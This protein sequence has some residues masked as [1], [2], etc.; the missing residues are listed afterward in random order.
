MTTI[1]KNAHPILGVIVSQFPELHETF[2]VRELRALREAGVALRIYSLKR[3]RDEIVHLESQSLLSQTTYVAW[4]APV[5]WWRAGCEGLRHPWR[6]VSTLRWVIQFHRWPPATAAKAVIV[7]V[8]AMAMSRLMRRDGVT[9]AHAH[10]ATMPTTAAAV[11]SRWLSVPMSFT[12]HAWDIF[13]PN[14]SLKE[15]V[16]LAAR[17]IPC[18]EYNRRYLSHF[19]PGDKR[20]IV[21][22]YHGVDLETFARSTDPAGDGANLPTPLFLSVG[23]LVDTKGYEVL[24]EAYQLLHE[25]GVALRAMIVGHGPLARHLRRRVKQLELSDVV[26]ITPAMPQPALRELYAR[27]YAFVLPCVVAKNGDRDGIPNVLLEAM[28]M[29]LPVVSTAVSGIPEAVHD[30]RDGLVVPAHDPIRLA[31]ALYLLIRKPTWARVLG[32]HGRMWAETQFDA[33]EHMARLVTHMNEAIEAYSGLH[34]AHVSTGVSES[35][36]RA[37]QA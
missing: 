5:V 26:E 33:R 17:V 22:N 28:A 20:K 7:W 37:E 32:D 14:A 29:G 35:S 9:H 25:R 24:L 23:R 11:V 19:C 36:V 16:R 30:K 6:R 13:V 21:L 15:K 18:T 31:D 27:A 3:C 12:A 8:Q 34:Q 2:I 1:R 10:W 4:D